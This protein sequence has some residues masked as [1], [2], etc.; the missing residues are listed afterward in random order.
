MSPVLRVFAFVC[1]SGTTKSSRRRTRIVAG[2]GGGLLPK[3]T[4]RELVTARS[5][6]AGMTAV[7]EENAAGAERDDHRRERDAHY[8]LVNAT[9]SVA[10]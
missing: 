10:V 5:K 3:R 8:C 6:S 1:G 7:S 2:A 9:L 4:R